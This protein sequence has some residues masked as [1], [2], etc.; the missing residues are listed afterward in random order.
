MAAATIA[1]RIR[2]A[3]QPRRYS[4]PPEAEQYARRPDIAVD[5]PERYRWITIGGG[6]KGEDGSRHPKGFPVEI[7]ESGKILKSRAPGLQGKSVSQVKEHFGEQR[8]K[9]K[10]DGAGTA[11][12]GHDDD[13][14]ASRPSVRR[15]EGSVKLKTAHEGIGP[16]SDKSHVSESLHGH[17]SDEQ[18]H[19]AALAVK[20]M[21]E[22]GGF[23]LADGTGVGKTRQALA[24]AKTMADSGKKVLIVTPKAVSKADFKKGTIAGSW[25]NDSKAMGVDVSLNNGDKELESGKVAMTTYENLVKIKDKIDGNTSIIFD[26]AHAFKNWQAARSKHGAEMAKAAHSVMY[27]TATP[28]DKVEHIGYL[29]RA[30]VFGNIGPKATFEKLG[31]KQV[32]Q[33]VGGGQYVKKWVVDGKVGAAGVMERMSALFEQL[34]REGKML[35]REISMEGVNVESKKI[36]LPPEAHEAMKKI[37]EIVGDDDGLAKARMLMEQRRQQE[38]YKV[39]YAVQDALEDI[40]AGH[41]VVIFASRVNASEVGEGDDAVGSEGTM[42]LLKDEF[43]KHGITDVAEIHGGIKDTTAEM[44][45]FQGGSHR[46][47]IATVESGGTGINLDDV[48][49]DKPRSLI[50]L[51]PPFSAVE[52]VQ[53]AGRVWRRTTKSYPKVKYLFGDTDV[54]E[55][56]SALI[57]KKMQTLGAT[58][59]GEM[60]DK[61]QQSSDFKWGPLNV[62][63][64]AP[65]PTADVSKSPSS[66]RHSATWTKLRS[67]DWGARIEGKASIGDEV[68]V[69]SK[70]GRTKTTK[71]KRVAWSGDGVSL[72]EVYAMPGTAERYSA[73]S[74]ADRIRE[75]ILKK[76]DSRQQL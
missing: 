21:K 57:T 67:G 71:V 52:N 16:E 75:S 30:G 66:G 12:D 49:G 13:R 55:W 15:V 58:V 22:S 39:P 54:D 33:H 76:L 63:R 5:D 64:E 14:G 18:V 46:V 34:T 53:A 61:E 36:T 9:S 19:G 43:A 3:M 60:G 6:P 45:K 27:A 28:A 50:M 11:S 44:G 68:T 17:L 2:L 26:E 47:V 35:R 70:D 59:A 62:Q 25:A 23:L 42:K 72:V 24:V 4:L 69:K 29:A 40:K 1:E 73:E 7:D 37:S 31:M 41:Q 74:L 48:T 20:A 10:P 8:G 65:K 32:D 51:T 56:N 38:P